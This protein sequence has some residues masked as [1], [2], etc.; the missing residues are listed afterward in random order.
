MSNIVEVIYNKSERFPK[1]SIN[2]EQISRYMELADLIYNDMYHWADKLYTSMDDELCEP[3]IILLTGHPFHHQILQATRSQSAYCSEIRFTPLVSKIPMADKMA[4]ATELNR[5][6]QLNIQQNADSICFFSDEPDRFQSLVS[7]SNTPSSYYITGGTNL[8]NVPIKC[9]IMLSDRLHF[10]KVQGIS[11]L[12]IP[13]HLLAMAV[14]YLNLYHL[15]LELITAIFSTASDLNLTE[16]NRLKFEAYLH[17][18]YRIQ[19]N[20]LPQTMNVGER[21]QV[22]YVYYPQ[23]FDD[24]QIL[25]STSNPSVLFAADN[26][27]IAQS[28]GSA[29]ILLTDKFGVTHGNYPVKVEY[30]NYVTDISI[31]LPATSLCVNETLRFKCLL[32]PNDAEDIHAVR[33]TINNT[34]VAAFSGQ[35]EIYGIAPGRIKVT[36]STARISKNFYLTV[37]PT[38]K[39]VLLPKELLEMPVNANAHIECSIVPSNASP[40][41]TVTWQSSNPRVLNITESEGY[42]CKAVSHEAGSAILKCS[43]D[44]TNI[45]KTMR[46]EVKK[47]KGCYV[48]TAVYGS[49][50]CPQVW[51]L[52]RYRDQFLSCHTLGRAF[53]KVYYT[54]SPTAVKWFGHTKWFNHLWR[55]IL[56]RMVRKLKACGYQDTPYND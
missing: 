52:R 22:S 36:I 41:P 18:E 14:D 47:P 37:L 53:I 28:A 19:I 44:G 54:L 39:D 24:P 35:N 9:C 12:H 49:Y 27:L 32:S 43:L 50:D 42:S 31:I 13:Q 6:Y 16:D 5:Q 17:E 56:D 20:N 40:K 2:G 51:A 11:V 3:Y 1:I 15:Q 46:V 45:Y 34:S 25:V 7:C 4:Y 55:S 33:Y 26:A 30:H 29:S 8:P 21:F 10:E 23:Q 38:A 48:A